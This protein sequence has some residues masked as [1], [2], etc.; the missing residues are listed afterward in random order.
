MNAVGLTRQ[1]QT[2]WNNLGFRDELL[3]WTTP[4]N[5]YFVQNKVPRDMLLIFCSGIMDLMM[6]STFARWSLYTPT[7]R[8][9]LACIQFYG[10]RALIQKLWFIEAPPGYAWEYP[11]V[12]SLYVPY[13]TTADFFYSG[14]VGICVIHY[15]E[16]CAIGWRWMSYFTLFVLVSQFFLMTVLRS[17]YSIDMISGMIIAYW[18]FVM[19]EKYSYIVDWWIFGIPL[20]KRIQPNYTEENTNFTT[21]KQDPSLSKDG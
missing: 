1:D 13:G 18:Q 21:R 10:E 12:M 14:H 2:S 20:Y 16:Y 8:F 19:A 4:L 17:H 6:I 11:G 7:W 15:M 3:I 9:I 5:D